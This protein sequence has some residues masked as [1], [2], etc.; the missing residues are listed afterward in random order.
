MSAVVLPDSSALFTSCHVIISNSTS[1]F[2]AALV[3]AGFAAAPDGVGFFAPAVCA[4][5]T[6]ADRASTER[7]PNRRCMVILLIL[8]KHLRVSKGQTDGP[9]GIVA[10]QCAAMMRSLLA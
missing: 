7:V 10:D 5:A 8:R 9:S 6:V 2:F 1:G 3:A 4:S